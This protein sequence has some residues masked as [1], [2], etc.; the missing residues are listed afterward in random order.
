MSY[1]SVTDIQNALQGIINF[2]SDGQTR[3]G[4]S[5]GG[6]ILSDSQVQDYIDQGEAFVS[7]KLGTLYLIPLQ[8]ANGNMSLDDF[9]DMTKNNLKALFIDETCIR[10]VSY[11][12]AQQGNSLELRN[13]LS[14]LKE[15]FMENMELSLQKDHS[16][17]IIYPAYPELVLSEK[18]LTREE[19]PI[20]SVTIGENTS[21]YNE[22]QKFRCL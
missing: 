1:I 15:R 14:S 8:D 22:I 4:S 7:R 2:G 12:F 21:C 17:G 13:Y 6:I 16:G 11:V 18:Y 3:Y 19:N 5:S 20:P 9:S 10:I